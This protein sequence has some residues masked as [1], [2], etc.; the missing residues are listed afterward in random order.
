VL[1]T[2]AVQAGT[3]LI[4]FGAD[5]ATSPTNGVQVWNNVSHLR[6][7]GSPSAGLMSL[8]A[9]GTLLFTNGS[10]SGFTFAATNLDGTAVKVGQPDVDTPG[11]TPVS[12]TGILYPASA[13]ADNMQTAGSDETT[14]YWVTLGNLDAALRYHFHFF[15][16]SAK[17]NCSGSA[18]AVTDSN[19]TTT[20]SIS[21]FG[22]LN[23]S[24][25]FQ[26]VEWRVP[27]ANREINI[28][29]DSPPGEANLYSRW[30]T[31]EMVTTTNTPP[32]P[33][34]PPEPTIWTNILVIT[35]DDLHREAL[36]CYGSPVPEISPNVDTFAA[37]GLR[38]T[39][40]HV[41]NP[42]C[43]PS[44]KVLASGLY[45]HNSGAMGFMKVNPEVITILDRLRDEGYKL[46]ILG[47]V[48]H[49][50]PKNINEWD[51]RH[52]QGELGGGR[53]PAKYYE[54]CTNF[55]NLCKAENKPFYFMVN[56]HD[57]HLP[58]Y[59]PVKGTT[60]TEEAVPSRL[61]GPND[62]PVPEHLP[63]IPG[64]RDALANF[65]NS[66]K[67]FDDTFGKVIQA[68]DE[69]GLR[70]NTLV[71]FQQDNGIATPFAKAN[72]YFASTRTPYIIQWPGV[73]SPGTVNTSLVEE[74]DFFPTVLDA[75]GLA[76]QAGDGQS[77]LP[78]LL[79]HTQD[80]GRQYVYTQIEALSSQK[81]FPMRCIQNRRYGYIYNM[82]SMDGRW[83]SNA[84]EHEVMAAMEEAA[85]T[86]PGIA[87]R[88]ELFRYRVPEELYD[89]ENDPGSLTNL[90]ESVAH[91]DVLAELRAAMRTRMVESTDPLLPAFDNRA[92]P[93]AARDVFAEA[94]P[95]RKL[96]GQAKYDNWKNA[97]GLVDG[98]AD[99]SAD[100]DGDGVDN[101]TEYAFGAIPTNG[102][103]GAILPMF[104][105]PAGGDFQTLEYVYRRRRDAAKRGLHY[106][107]SLRTDLL[108]GC[109]TEAGDTETG[110]AIIDSDFEWVTNSISTASTTN[111]F[112]RLKC[113]AW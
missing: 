75:L 98:D 70:D 106:D 113:I 91:Q 31:L 80:T 20:V 38:F 30:N 33:P 4:D 103:N 99:Y 85:L 16:S 83:Y 108:N 64:V 112:M 73:V 23:N 45:G 107:F 61:Y 28:L 10:D 68:L 84:N 60:F 71:L 6:Q 7:D 50:S 92:N 66:T 2:A 56:S 67:R 18:W 5:D 40:A 36:G 43:E 101:M 26:T 63:D 3:I 76:P 19:G 47:K 100:P 105:K 37:N 111:G 54:Y 52:D 51:F 90:L 88:I 65:Y 11:I 29:F 59:D 1:G 87:A 58:W 14:R 35:A 24:N 110:T 32:E 72:A 94:Y 78:I 12:P 44:R 55:F 53:N 69:S 62:F 22:V 95:N 57:P 27:D 41:N 86:D 13:A 102:N 39:H 74:V 21:A 81:A 93:D 34:E 82:W 49:S 48:G 89:L 42:I 15:A 25:S 79:D 17:V 97:Y 96:T 77:I 104:G 46:G 8:D 9:G 109:W